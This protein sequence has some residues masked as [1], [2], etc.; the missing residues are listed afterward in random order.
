MACHTRILSSVGAPLT[1]A[2][3][4]FQQLV[5][6]TIS[7][8]CQIA[9]EYTGE[10]VGQKMS[11]KLQE[12]KVFEKTQMISQ[13]SGSNMVAGFGIFDLPSLPCLAHIIQNVVNN[14]GLGKSDSV[15]GKLLATARKLVSHF[16]HSPKATENLKKFQKAL[17]LS[18]KGH[19]L[20]RAELTRWN[21]QIS[22]TNGSADG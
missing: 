8:Y 13:D 6:N 10:N 5:K 20:L 16:K 21:T 15:I 22:I 11:E 3:L 14:D 4:D 9:D 2:A 18:D 12:N 7:T 17:L 1:P 19:H